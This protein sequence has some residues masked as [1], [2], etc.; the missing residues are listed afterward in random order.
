M[1]CS[2]CACL[3]GVALVA[4]STAASAQENRNPEQLFRELDKNSDGKVTSEEVGQDRARFF[5]RLVRS[6]DKDGDGALSREEFTAALGQRP[7]PEAVPPREGRPPEGRP[8]F[9]GF[10]GFPFERL[11]ANGDGKLTLEE[12]PEE[13]RD[14]LR[15]LFERLGKDAITREDIARLSPFGPAGGFA[16]RFLRLLDE[17]SDGRLD[18]EEWSKAGEK[19][20]ELDTNQDG[21]LDGQELFGFPAGPPPGGD[22]RLLFGRFAEQ[23]FQRIDRDGDGKISKEEAPERMRENFARLDRNSDGEIDLEEFRAGFPGPG[24]RPEGEQP[25]RPRRPDNE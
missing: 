19:F 6:G 1:K 13:A 2:V 22:G 17:N 21:Q 8:F 14:R 9:G 11:D 12:V 7:R 20:A 16:P 25:R 3:A 24:Q 23:M 4:G 15:P 18:K 5:E 10:G